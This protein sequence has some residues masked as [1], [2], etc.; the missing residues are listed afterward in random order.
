MRVGIFSFNTEAVKFCSSSTEKGCIVADFLRY[1]FGKFEQAGCDIIVIGLQESSAFDSMFMAISEIPNYTLLSADRMMGVG[2]EGLRGLRL[3]IVVRNSFMSHSIGLYDFTNVSCRVQKLGKGA[4]SQI[5]VS[6]EKHSIGFTTAHLP[7]QEKH[8]RQGVEDRNEC[9]GQLM[10]VPAVNSVDTAFIFGDLNYRLEIPLEMVD[11]IEYTDAQTGYNWMIQYDQLTESMG[12]VIPGFFEG[13]NGQGPD[14]PP[15]CKLNVGR[16]SECQ[17][18]TFNTRCFKTTSGK[19]PRFPSWCDRI[20]Y[21]GNRV[22]CDSYEMV[23]QGNMSHS[24]HRGVLG[25]FDIVIED[26]GRRAVN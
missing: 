25:V 23:D 26:T 20:L 16:R 3:G 5:L 13:V 22:F 24:D 4:F 17:G 18:Q 15:T 11:N 9:L 10:E 1:I 2:K 6:D 21:R 14:F 7:F 8:H 12:L 19:Q